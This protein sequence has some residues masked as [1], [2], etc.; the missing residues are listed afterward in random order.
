MISTEFIITLS[1][2]GGVAIF[3]AGFA[4]HTIVAENA[5]LKRRVA[6]LEDRSPKRVTNRH[7]RNSE[8]YMAHTNHVIITMKEGLEMLTS[9]HTMLQNDRQDPNYD[10]EPENGRKS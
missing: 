2:F 8:N 7:A 4:V 9:L 1:I 5:D 3:L 6:D 10:T